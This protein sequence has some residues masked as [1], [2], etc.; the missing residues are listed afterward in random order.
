MGQVMLSQSEADLLLRM[1]KQRE[2]NR[3]WEYPNSGGHLRIP[4][5][6]VDGKES[7][8]LDAGRGR[9]NLQ[10]RKLQHR[11]R[12]VIVLARLDYGGAPH[13]NPDGEEVGST[14]LHLYREGYEDKWAFPI[15]PGVFT[16]IGNTMKTLDEFMRFCHIIV[17]PIIDVDLYD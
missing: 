2:S 9:L 10:K 8:L 1:E 7:F 15:D 17:A 13:R 3:R 12:Q 6:S 5:I 14:H 11:A 4:L 16:E